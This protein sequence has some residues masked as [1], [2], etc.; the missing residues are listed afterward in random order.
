MEEFYKLGAEYEFMDSLCATLFD[1]KAK[2]YNVLK[3]QAIVN[4]AKRRV[5]LYEHFLKIA[6]KNMG[7]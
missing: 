3:T 1:V 5:E 4:I 2:Y 7:L 6:K